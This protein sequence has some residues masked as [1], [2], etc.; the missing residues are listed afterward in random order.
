M[1]RRTF[2]KAALTIVAGIAIASIVIILN[3]QLAFQS[4]IKRD[5]QLLKPAPIA[6]VLG[7]S[8]KQD[9]TASDALKDRILK[10]DELY[11]LG[12]VQGLLMTGDDGAFHTDEVD[13]M[14]QLAIA[15]G[16]P[17]AA[18]QVDPHGYRTYESCKRAAGEYHITNAIIVTQAFHLPR[19]LYLCEHFGIQSQGYVADR[20]PYIKIIQ[21]T[22]RDWL[23]SALAWWEINIHEPAP[24]V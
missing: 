24:P 4:A 12:K 13:V 11:R 2:V 14:C 17:E 20:Q 16:I 15:D 3:V 21:F 19:A 7:A 23:A 6:I 9:G 5:A 22:I 8:V 1:T 10:A 18:I